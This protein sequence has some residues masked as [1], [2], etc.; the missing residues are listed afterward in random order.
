MNISIFYFLYDF[1]SKYDWLDCLIRFFAEPF[2]FII[3]AVLTIALIWHSQ[4]FRGDNSIKSLWSKGRGIAIIIFS[5]GLTYALANLL[6]LI[7]QTDRPFILLPDIHT[8]VSESGYAFPSG[9]S[10]TIAAFAF[11][12]FFK[13]KKIGYIAL[14]AMILIGL[15]RVAAGV[16]FP[17]DIM[18]GYALGFVVAFLLKSR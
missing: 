12:V 7:I 2:I 18:G 3:I 8:L 14:V 9:H 13:N 17:I 10:A 15:A 4:V 6:K 11:G 5:T 16:H 1:S